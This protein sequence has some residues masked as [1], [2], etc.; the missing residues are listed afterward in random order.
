MWV[1]LMLVLVSLISLSIQL[2]LRLR[3]RHI[4]TLP[5]LLAWDC[6]GNF[7]SFRFEV[8]RYR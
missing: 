5:C 3:L 4:E 7:V 1:M 2:R 8:F 6:D